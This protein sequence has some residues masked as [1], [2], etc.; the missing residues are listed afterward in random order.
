MNYNKIIV[1]IKNKIIKIILSK[2][3]IKKIFKKG[4]IKVYI[5]IVIYM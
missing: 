3:I 5:C 1:G 4:K 2:N